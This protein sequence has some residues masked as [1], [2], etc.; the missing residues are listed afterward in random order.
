MVLRDYNRSLESAYVHLEGNQGAQD[1]LD[2]A[3]FG[4]P[5]FRRVLNCG[6]DSGFRRL[7]P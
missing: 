4:A 3:L 6:V 2:Y 7:Q 5:H 1:L